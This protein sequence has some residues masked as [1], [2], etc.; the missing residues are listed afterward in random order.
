MKRGQLLV[1]PPRD[2]AVEDKAETLNSMGALNTKLGV[3]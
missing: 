2:E 1:L 3:T